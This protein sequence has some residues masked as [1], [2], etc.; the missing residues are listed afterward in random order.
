MVALEKVVGFEIF[1]VSAPPPF[2]RGDAEGLIADAV[3]VIA[4]H[5]PQTAALYARR[6]WRLPQH[7]GRIYD[8]AKAERLLGFRARTD[9]AAVLEALRSGAR[10]PFAHDP[11]YVSPS[12][13]L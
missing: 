6:G 12:T 11:D 8:P 7:I 10:L 5:F 9:F 4:R 3:D 1:I 13:R 2:A